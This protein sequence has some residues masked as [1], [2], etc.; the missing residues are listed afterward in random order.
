MQQKYTW[1]FQS[2][3]Y[4]LLLIL[5]KYVSLAKTN[6]HIATDKATAYVASAGRVCLSDWLEVIVHPEGPAIGHLTQNSVIFLGHTANAELLKSTLHCMFL[7][8]PS[9]N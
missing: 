7:R 3:L 2:Y 1:K 5:R 8:Q 9:P 4:S 6:L